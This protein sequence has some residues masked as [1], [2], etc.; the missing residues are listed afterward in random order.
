[1]I[2][3]ELE[4]TGISLGTIKNNIVDKFNNFHSG[5]TLK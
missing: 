4:K 5:V 2:I 3:D 1:M